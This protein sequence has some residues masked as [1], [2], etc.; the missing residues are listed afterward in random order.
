MKRVHEFET[1]LREQG[2]EMVGNHDDQHVWRLPNGLKFKVP[3]GGKHADAKDYLMS[4]YRRMM[5]TG[6]R[7]RAEGDG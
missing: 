1:F 2:C 4:K 6:P 3:V 5:R 7:N